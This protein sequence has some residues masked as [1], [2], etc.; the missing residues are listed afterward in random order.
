MGC[1][2]TKST[3]CG[4]CS[5][6][7]KPTCPAE[8]CPEVCTSIIIG[9]SWN[10]PACGEKA[11]VSAPGLKSVLIGSYLYNPTYGQFKITA[12]DSINS[13]VTILNECYV[14]NAPAGTVVPALTQFILSAGANAGQ[15]VVVL[16]DA[17]FPS[18]GN[19]T[20]LNVVGLTNV[21][22]G[23]YIWHPTY[24]YLRIVSYN[25][26][27]S[28]LT[29]QNDCLCPAGT[30]PNILSGSVF[31]ITDPP[32]SDNLSSGVAWAVP[33]CGA[34]VDI[35]AP[36]LSDVVIGSYIY[37]PTFG[38]FLVTAY[39]GGNLTVQNT[40]L[41][42]N[43]AGGTNVPE[44]TSFIFVDEPVNQQD[45]GWIATNVDGVFVAAD[46]FTL[47][48]D[49]TALIGPGDRIKLTNFTLKYLNVFSA[50]FGAGVTTFVV[51]AGD[52]FTL[53]AGT[54]EDVFYSHELNP[55]GFPD[56]FTWDPVYDSG[57]SVEPTGGVFV[58]RVRG[59]FIELDFADSG[60]GTSDST[61]YEV[62]NLPAPMLA[63]LY[64]GALGSGVDNSVYQ[65]NPILGEIP[66]VTPTILIFTLDSGGG[67]WTAANTKQAR[68]TNLVYR[69][70][71]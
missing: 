71:L 65:T 20:N 52:Q 48:G 31:V 16:S 69:F 43:V 3:S 5:N 51:F 25:A 68:V 18:C 28:A 26:P 36:L 41:A 6:C 40:C 38:H 57:F 23:A 7:N 4:R 22:V 9:N 33:N 47:P 45:D 50:V 44:C 54:I 27:T 37:N 58:F 10:V 8:N 62:S 42:G 12:F 55:F 66:G 13:I 60:D 56:G 30:G 34:T 11:V 46:S 32:V 64:A 49:W 63:G 14:G 35:D 70:A 24:G 17:A 19:T 15:S 59:K 67:T 53:A 21:P 2:C 29:V 61:D 1:G 39:A